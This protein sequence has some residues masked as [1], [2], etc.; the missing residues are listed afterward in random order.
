MNAE[1][2]AAIPQ[3][4]TSIS[5]IAGSAVSRDT[6]LVEAIRQVVTAIDAFDQSSVSQLIDS[7]HALD[8]LKNQTI[9]VKSGD[10]SIHGLNL[11]IDADGQLQLE[12][13]QGRQVFSAADIS[14]GSDA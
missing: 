8:T 13:E 12:T 4:A 9:T 11:G 3:P 6:I 10:G 14:I 1:D 5:L 2:F 7:F